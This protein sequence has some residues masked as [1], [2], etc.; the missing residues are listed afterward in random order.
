[1]NG[2]PVQTTARATA[3][4]GSA[5]LRCGLAATSLMAL[6]SLGA[7]SAAG[8]VPVRSDAGQPV[9]VFAHSGAT[10][11][12][13]HHDEPLPERVRRDGRGRPVHFREVRM[14]PHREAACGNSRCESSD[15]RQHEDGGQ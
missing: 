15:D 13:T 9:A 1:M 14:N 12:S 3:R 4:A 5:L 6:V 11:K 8:P 2:K 7:C 10:R